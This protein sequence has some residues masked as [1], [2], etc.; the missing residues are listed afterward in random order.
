[1]NLDF[2]HLSGPHHRTVPNFGQSLILTL[3]VR[4]LKQ[5]KDLLA[6]MP[7]L[8]DSVAADFLSSVIASNTLSVPLRVKSRTILHDLRVSSLVRRRFLLLLLTESE[9][10]RMLLFHLIY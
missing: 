10:R 9:L 5:V 1:M 8:Q 6:L 3:N 2:R 7:L 4:C